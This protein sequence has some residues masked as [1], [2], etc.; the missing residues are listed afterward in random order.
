MKVDGGGMEEKNFL[1][2]I[3]VLRR[4]KRYDLWN[5]TWNK[6]ISSVYLYVEY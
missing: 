4:V 2:L 3:L 6:S 1:I 5:S